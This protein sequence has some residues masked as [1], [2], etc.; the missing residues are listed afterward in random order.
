[1]LEK[2]SDIWWLFS[3][4]TV[5]ITPKESVLKSA[6]L[7]RDRNFR[8]LP[9]LEE[10][11]IVGM[12][13]V[14]DLVDSLHLMLRS[15][16][17]A[18][19]VKRSLEIPVERIMSMHPV[20]VELWDGLYDVVK[21]FCFYDVGA[22]PVVDEHGTVQGIVTLR[23]LVGLMGTSSTPLGVS[24][25]E[26]MNVNLTTIDFDSSL[27]HAV[28]LMSLRRV[29]RL[30]IITERKVTGVITNRDILRQIGK[31]AAGGHGPSGFGKSISEFMTRD[32]LTVSGDED[33]RAAAS[34]MMIFGVGGLIINDLPS[35]GVALV[36][37]RDLV[38]RLAA[39][40]SVK[41][42][43]EALQYEIEVEEAAGARPS[44]E[45]T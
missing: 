16:S 22:L 3:R 2:T 33:V 21:K 45:P 10:G 7:M 19:K 28:D 26:V 37:E 30:P 32:V 24:V 42:L 29:R 17:S 13:S 8:H 44:T 4:Q 12:I 25:N 41:F 9:V 5:S 39:K 15:S 35:G 18:E 1:M 20:V 34:M 27:A 43:T 6:L 36:T 38:R 14:Q 31:I 11:Q 23:D 40:R